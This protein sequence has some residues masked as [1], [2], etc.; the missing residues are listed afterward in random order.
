MRAL[1]LVTAATIML[2]W[3]L[4]FKLHAEPTKDTSLTV[5]KRIEYILKE[6]QSVERDD[7]LKN[8]KH[9]ECNSHCNTAFP[10]IENDSDGRK[11][12]RTECFKSC[13]VWNVPG[14]GGC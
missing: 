14:M 8:I 11:A 12:D 13:D 6:R 9:D 1:R 5:L 7:R 4:S 2:L 10:Y 3:L